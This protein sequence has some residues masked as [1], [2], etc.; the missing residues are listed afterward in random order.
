MI[1]VYWL[2]TLLYYLT[3]AFVIIR[4]NVRDTLPTTRDEANGFIS[5]MVWMALLGLGCL[6]V[7]SCAV[8]GTR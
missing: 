2:L 3:S 8:A 6:V 7:V 5:G 1:L 4:N